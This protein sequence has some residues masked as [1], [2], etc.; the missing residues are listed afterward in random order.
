VFDFNERPEA[1]ITQ[2]PITPTGNPKPHNPTTQKPFH[3]C[4]ISEFEV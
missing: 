3:Y 4:N 2:R 1:V